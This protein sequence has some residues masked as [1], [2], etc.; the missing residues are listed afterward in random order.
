MT[1]RIQECFAKGD[2]Y[3]ALF[4]DISKAFDS[5]WHAGLMHKIWKQ[6]IR[7]HAWYWIRCFLTNRRFRVK[8]NNSFSSWFPNTAGV[9]QGSDIAALLFLIFINDLPDAYDFV[10]M[11]MFADD[12]SVN[13]LKKTGKI[14]LEHLINS[15]PKITAWARKWKVIFSPSKSNVVIFSR[16][17]KPPDIPPLY[18]CDLQ[19]DI[20]DEYTYLGMTLDSRLSWKAHAAKVTSKAKSIC[21]LISRTISRTRPPSLGAIRTLCNTL[22]RS[23]VTYGLQFWRPTQVQFQKL[24]SLYF[25]PL[26]RCLS[27][28]LS[29]HQLSLAIECNTVPLDL[30]RM[31]M[32]SSTIARFLLLPPSHPT[33]IMY[34]KSFDWHTAH[35]K[36]PATRRTYFLAQQEY[37]YSND[38]APFTSSIFISPS[39]PYAHH[40]WQSGSGGDSL[41]PLL[42]LSNSLPSYLLLDDKL[43]CTIRARLRFNRSNMNTSLFKMNM[44]THTSCPYCPFE[45]ETLDHVIHTC[46]IYNM[47]QHPLRN[48]LTQSLAQINIPLTN[49][50]IL[51]KVE[52][53][54]KHNKARSLINPCV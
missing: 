23:S 53:L 38:L 22:L 20:V 32:I 42:C 10:K 51:G 40:K 35:L 3:P 47:P 54:T 37:Y 18:L 9:P 27:L 39:R 48:N 4:L 46:P 49:D 34:L 24:N 25:M 41:K 45:E 13:P 1:E 43:T 17:H 6:G 8:S 11:L 15:L 44:S 52:H 2:F 29:T 28:P 31:D 21:Y 30:Y 5:V 50:L 12:V 7:G 19:L 16:K 33:R 14:A 26:R 36:N